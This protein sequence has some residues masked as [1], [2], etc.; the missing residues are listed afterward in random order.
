MS[1]Y[2]E[3]IDEMHFTQEKVRQFRKDLAEKLHP[4]LKNTEVKSSDLTP[5]AYQLNDEDSMLIREIKIMQNDI[6]AEL[7]ILT[8]LMHNIDL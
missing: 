2:E 7:D 6:H 8:E 4:V 3:V 1:K 5:E